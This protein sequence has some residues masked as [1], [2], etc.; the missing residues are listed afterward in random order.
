MPS[1]VFRFEE[2]WELPGAKVRQ[3]YDVLSRG[4]LLPLWWK[5]VYLEAEKLTPGGE[6]KVG[7]RVRA[8]A[9]GFLPYVLNFIVE[10]IELVPEYRV[11]VK[12]IGDFDGLWSA[13]LTQTKTGVRAD[14]VWEVTVLLPILRL[15]APLLRPAL[16]WNHRWTTPRGEKGLREYLD[17]HQ[18]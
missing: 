10:V 3:V 16:A 1:N 13:V 14:L 4:E 9:R 2:S 6:P 5:G 7:D 11:V 12:T 18:E 17:A 8:R 15:L